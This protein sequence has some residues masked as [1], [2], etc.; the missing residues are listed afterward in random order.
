MSLKLNLGSG[1]RPLPG[2]INIDLHS[3]LANVKLDCSLPLPFSNDSIDEIY[4]MHLIEH[5]SLLEWPV[6]KKDWYRILKPGGLLTIE[7]PDLDRCLQ[8]FLHNSQDRKWTYWIRAIYGSQDDNDP[9]QFHKNG[10][11]LEKLSS[12]LKT[13]G[14]NISGHE[15]LYYETPDPDGFCL[16]MTAVK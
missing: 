2:Y 14:F 9:G 15:Y 11:T 3:Q 5:F 10:F 7:C 16:K 12:D 1:N 8:R 4:A 13:E 6:I